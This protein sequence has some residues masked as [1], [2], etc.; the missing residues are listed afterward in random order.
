MI[1]KK[2]LYL[3]QGKASALEKYIFGPGNVLKISLNLLKLTVG[4]MF[5]WKYMYDYADYF[6]YIKMSDFLVN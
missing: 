1:F 5:F 2:R 3:K 4:T 6:D